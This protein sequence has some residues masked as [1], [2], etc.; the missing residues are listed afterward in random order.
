MKIINK[1]NFISNLVFLYLLIFIFLLSYTFYQAE[2]VHKGNQFSY[3]KKYYLIFSSTILFWVFSLFLNKKKKLVII[4]FSTSII[5]ILYFYE[6][7]RFYA[8]AINESKIMKLINNEN[9]IEPKI[10]KDSKINIINELKISKG[11]D[12]VPSVFPQALINK[13]LDLFP[14]G[15][16]SNTTTV[17]CKEGKEYSIYTSDRYGFNNSDDAWDKKSLSWF[18]VGDS[19]TQGSCVKQEENFASQIL[20]I[21]KKGA[22]SVGMSGNGP[23][24]ELATVREYATHIK[25]E[26]VLWIYFE[27]NDLEDL[28]KEKSDFLLMK[29]MNEDFSQ[30]LYFKQK[31]VDKKLKESILK[32]EREYKNKKLLKNKK[33]KSYNAFQKIIRLQI[34]RDKMALDRGLDFGVDPLFEKIISQAKSDINRW[35]GKLYFVYLP[36]KERYTSNKAHD[37]NYLKRGTVIELIE[38][39]NIPV[40]DVHKDFFMKQNDPL[41]FYAHRIY[42][43]FNPE[44]Y[45]KISEFIVEKIK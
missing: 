40:I 5:F 15:G 1:N 32:A 42:G 8:P 18:L 41:S 10:N 31:N 33:I 7:I 43:H 39:L 30:N 21:T 23:L 25:P 22:V 16:V 24:I 12:V 36:D 35:G 45:K 20:N 4:Y 29:Y 2:L 17:F 27:R 13:N 6:T 3:Y 44:G 28:K 34:L 37:D 14:L 38:N 19:F 9:K 26:I 11:I